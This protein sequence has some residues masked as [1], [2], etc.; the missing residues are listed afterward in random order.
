MAQ[1]VILAE[2]ENLAFSYNEVFGAFMGVLSGLMS[3]PLAE[4][5]DYVI[6]WDGTEYTRTA[7]AF[8][9]PADGTNC[10]AIGNPIVYGGEDNGD[11]FAIVY[12][13]TNDYAYAFS[14][15]TDATHTVAIYAAGEEE[16]TT[17]SANIIIKNYSGNDVLY[18]GVKKVYFTGADG[19]SKVPYTYG[20]AITT[21]VE[22]DFSDGD[23]EVDIAEGTLVTGMTIVRPKNLVPE[24]IKNGVSIAGIS[25]MLATETEEVTVEL[26]LADGDQE[27]LPATTGAA[28]SKVTITKPDTLIPENIAKDVEIAGII[29]THE[30][31]GTVDELANDPE[32]IDDM[33]FWDYDGTL[34]AHFPMS[35]ISNL[36]E[37]P[38]LPSHDGLIFQGWNYT[39][40][41]VRAAKYPYDVGAIYAT[42]DGNTHLKLNVTN[43]SYLAVPIHFS[44]DVANGVTIDWG[45]GSTSS[46]DTVGVTS[47]THTYAIGTYEVTISVADGC[48]MTLGGGTSSTVFVGG[49]KSAY[50]NYLL[51]LY[52][53]N[54]VRIASYCLYGPQNLSLLTIPEMEITE[55]PAYVVYDWYHIAAIILPRC[56]TATGDCNFYNMSSGYRYATTRVSL[57]YTLLTVGVNFMY[58]SHAIERCSV[59]PNVT[60][61]KNYSFYNLYVIKRVFLPDGI[62]SIGNSCFQIAPQLTK[63]NLPANLCSVGNSCF[64][65]TNIRDLVLPETEFTFGLQFCQSGAVERL[66]V[67]GSLASVGGNAFMSTYLLKDVIFLN[68]TPTSAVKTLLTGNYVRHVNMYFPDEAVSAYRTTCASTYV[69]LNSFPLSEY[70]GV[71]PD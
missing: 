33:C 4:G 62:T 38:T 48:T 44:Q 9:N 65:M 28:M 24:N 19:A 70:R 43:S 3:Q 60:A 26:D 58:T 47:L 12:D 32:W 69:N 36:T 16:T 14:T 15:T 35:N 34:V 6:S 29:G 27:V 31:G 22:P 67:K 39:L 64:Y 50:K 21:S 68:E 11:S 23:M 53:G 30:G 17:P 25:G 10:V 18:E 8:T 71:L 37:L 45:D 52:I 54:N 13:L 51:E 1:E 41:E 66:V 49:S 20:D 55:L 56:I 7:V 2:Q 5:E 42:S 63:L 40:E 61:I 59:P 57:P 46:S